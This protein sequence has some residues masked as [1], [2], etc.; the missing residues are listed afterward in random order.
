MERVVVITL[1]V[2]S[3]GNRILELNPPVVAVSATVAWYVTFDSTFG[4]VTAPANGASEPFL[5]H[6]ATETNVTR[7]D[8]IWPAF[9]RP[10][11]RPFL[12]TYLPLDPHGN[13]D[14]ARLTIEQVFAATER[15]AVQR[16]CI[17]YPLM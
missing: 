13:F 10:G 4:P 16:I 7:L 15:A 1:R 6:V 8:D 9:G 12:A 2:D 17:S 3:D 5:L 14:N 11:H